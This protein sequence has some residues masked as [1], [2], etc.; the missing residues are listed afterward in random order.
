LNQSAS[1]DD[2]TVPLKLSSQLGLFD[3]TMM[4]MGGI[5]GAGIFMNPYVVAQ[6]LHSPVLILSVW[7]AGGA[8]A[9]LGAFIYA[10]LGDRIPEVGGQYEYLRQALHPVFGF[11]YGWALLLVIQTGGMAAVAVTFARYFLELT[12]LPVSESSVVIATLAVLTAINCLGVK[13]GGRLQSI[14]MVLKIG[15]IACLVGAGFFLLKKPQPLFHP[16]LDRPVSFDLLTAIGAAMVPVL[17]SYGGWQTTNFIASE[18]RDPRKNLARALI[19]G[20]VAVV[21]LYVS[22][23]LVCVRALGATALAQTNVPASAVMRLVAGEPGARLIALGI[24]VSTVGFLSQSVLTAPRVYF[25]MAKDK[26]FFRSVAYLNPKT[27][28]PVVAIVLQSVWAVVIA[29]TGKYEQILNFFVPIDF[30]FF[31]LSAT[32]LFV[33][34]HRD[35]HVPPKH[36]G[37]RVPGHPLTTI[38]FILSCWAIVVNTLYKYPRNSFIGVFI[39]LLGVPVYLLWQRRQDQEL[40]Q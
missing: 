16:V 37:F 10:E 32:C 25:A 29:L 7:L 33:L 19:I 34:R 14:L 35:Q 12:G 15:A 13:P 11:L 27:H 4:V 23:N 28:V 18:I 5:V 30:L 3:A 6:R 39:L 31:G 2:R 40:L 36:P 22:V 1:S 26:L 24:A 38:V 21:I 20:V 9:I 17:F 8:V